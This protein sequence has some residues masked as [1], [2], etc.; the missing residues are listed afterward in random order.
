[1]NGSELFLIFFFFLV[2]R[3]EIIGS[4]LFFSSFFS[5]F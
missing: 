2:F 5:I 1:M 3:V 4:E